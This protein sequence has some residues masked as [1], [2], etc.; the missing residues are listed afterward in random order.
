[1][2]APREQLVQIARLIGLDAFSE[3]FGPP[4]TAAPDDAALRV[5][6]DERLDDVVRGLVEEAAASDDVLDVESALAYLDDRLYTLGAL[7]TPEQAE[8]IRAAFAERTKEW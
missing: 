6:I 2:A 8:V 5:L 3:R 1:V 7:I 4:Q